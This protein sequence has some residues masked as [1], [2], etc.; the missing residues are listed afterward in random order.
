[1]QAHSQCSETFYRK[2]IQTSIDTKSSKTHEEREKML[3]LLKRLEEQTQ[4]EDS[5]S[6]LRDQDES[7]SDTNDL[8][9]R[10]ADVDICTWFFPLS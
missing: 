2:E 1:M 7:D 9:S 5:S 6:L 3:E 8:V 10:F 4:E